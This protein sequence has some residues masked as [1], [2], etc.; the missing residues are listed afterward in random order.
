MYKVKVLKVN[1]KVTM[2]H[3][4][5]SNPSITYILDRLCYFAYKEKMFDFSMYLIS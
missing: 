4:S 1:S 3:Y 2:M 5:Y